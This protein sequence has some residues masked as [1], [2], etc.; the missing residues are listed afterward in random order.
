[1]QRLTIKNLNIQFDNFSQKSDFNSPVADA[2]DMVN[3][4]NEVL[5]RE[6][7]NEQPQIM[8]TSI[9]DDDV[10]AEDDGD[11]EAEFYCYGDTDDKLVI[12]LN[13][14]QKDRALEDGL[15]FLNKQ[16]WR[17]DVD[18]F[19]ELKLLKESTE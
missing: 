13:E 18:D 11:D 7:P 9:D 3:R 17:F 10:E 5:Q 15:I 12:I 6:F 8:E 1:M 14:F 16:G 2:Q 19:D 4:I